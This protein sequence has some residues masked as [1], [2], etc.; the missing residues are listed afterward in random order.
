MKEAIVVKRKPS[1]SPCDGFVSHDWPGVGH[2]IQ[3]DMSYSTGR[4]RFKNESKDQYIQ[5]VIKKVH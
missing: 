2:Y 3:Y 1:E 4:L 5:S